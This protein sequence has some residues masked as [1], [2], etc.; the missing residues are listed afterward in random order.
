MLTNLQDNVGE[1][2]LF[3]FNER[4]GCGEVAVKCSSLEFGGNRWQV[5]RIS[6]NL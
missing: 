2:K 5:V 3:F 6:G 1:V 4:M